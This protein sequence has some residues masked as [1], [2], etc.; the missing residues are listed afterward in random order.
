MGRDTVNQDAR[1][2]QILEISGGDRVRDPR[3]RIV[4][5][6]LMLLA[7]TVWSYWPIMVKLFEEWQTNDDYSAGQLVPLVAIFLVWHDRKALGSCLLRPSWLWGIVLLML[8]QAARAYGLLFMFESAERYS[9]VLTVAGLVLLVVGWKV[10]HRVK[11]ILLFLFLMIPFPGRI[12]NLISG[13]LQRMATMGSVFLLEAFGVRV[14]QQGN[15]VTLNGNTPLAVAEACSGLRMLTAFIIVA[16]FIACMVNRSRLQR[17]ILLLSSIPV[18]VLCNI[19]RISVTAVLMLLVNADVAQKFFHDFAGIVMMPAAVLLMFAE[20]WVMDRLVE[21][22]P[23]SKHR[24]AV[25]FVNSG[26]RPPV[27]SA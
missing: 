26:A 25:G 2:R 22:E 10:L 17:A 1:R 13:P 5:A 6:V 7:V 18:A 27:R 8:A 4:P 9:L 14:S 20:I 12:H 23:N 15:V 16:A 19:A 3:L 24:R 11:W 21:P